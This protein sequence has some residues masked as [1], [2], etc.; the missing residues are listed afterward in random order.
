MKA[1]H[2]KGCPAFFV[3]VCK[4][5]QN[6]IMDAFEEK[7]DILEYNLKAKVNLSPDL[8]LSGKQFR[9]VKFL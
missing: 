4:I 7:D 9:K 6:T 2:S 3:K 5:Q 8:F 1:G